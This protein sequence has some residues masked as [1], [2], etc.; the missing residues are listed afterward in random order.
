MEGTGDIPF[1]REIAVSKC[2]SLSSQMRTKCHFHCLP[3]RS[4]WSL[5]TIN[6]LPERL[7][8]ALYESLTD[9]VHLIR[10]PLPVTWI[11]RETL[12]DHILWF[13]L[14]VLVNNWRNRTE[15]NYYIYFK[16]YLLNV[17]VGLFSFVFNKKGI[18][19]LSIKK[20]DS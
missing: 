13:K 16:I 17:P 5:S 1:I 12:Q 19:S 2:W 4:I 8:S 7:I 11:N 9:H 15:N 18:Y 3:E 6:V 20:K 14:S 10:H